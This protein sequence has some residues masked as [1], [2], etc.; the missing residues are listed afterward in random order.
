VSEI[1]ELNMAELQGW[2]GYFSWKKT[3]QEEQERKWRH[4]RK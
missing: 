1:V 2:A 4:K 3:Q